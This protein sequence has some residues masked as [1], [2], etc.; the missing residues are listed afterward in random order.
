MPIL[1]LAVGAAARLARLTPEGSALHTLGDGVQVWRRGET[2]S[3]LLDA[4]A[5]AG[6][7]ASGSQPDPATADDVST[8]TDDESGGPLSLIVDW[9][10]GGS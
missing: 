3:D 7:A 1:N 5:T 4:A 6:P 8:G 9:L 2:V 10:F